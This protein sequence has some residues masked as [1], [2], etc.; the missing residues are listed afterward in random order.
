MTPITVMRMVNE[1]MTPSGLLLRRDAVRVGY[2][3]NALARL[4][5]RQSEQVVRNKPVLR[6][7]DECLRID[8]TYVF[9]VHMRGVCHFAE[10]RGEAAIALKVGAVVNRVESASSDLGMFRALLE[11][12]EG[13]SFAAPRRRTPRN[14]TT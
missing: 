5:A 8:P 11:C 7:D 2:D 9:A 10:A 12:I 3:D 1:L 4:F 6:L 13:A 14:P